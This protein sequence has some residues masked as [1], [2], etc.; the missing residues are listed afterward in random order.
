MTTRHLVM[1][2]HSLGSRL[3]L[4]LEL[5]DVLLLLASRNPLHEFSCL[6]WL[7]MDLM[8]LFFFCG[9]FWCF[10]ETSEKRQSWMGLF[11]LVQFQ[12][13]AAYCSFRDLKVQI[14]RDSI[15]YYQQSFDWRFQWTIRYQF[16]CSVILWI[17]CW[18]CCWGWWKFCSSM[19]FRDTLMGTV[20]LAGTDM[21]V[22]FF[23]C[24][25]FWGLNMLK[26]T[27][28][29]V[30]WRLWS[31]APAWEALTHPV[32][33]KGATMARPPSSIPAYIEESMKLLVCLIDPHR[34][35]CDNRTH[36]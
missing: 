36:Q 10:V 5:M 30:L 18:G 35:P 11:D 2:N 29:I 32:G 8:V 20:G 16:I 31:F 21:M 27:E 19:T 15:H 24:D 26:R 4:M 28:T 17:H 1:F 6:I 34:A 23:F 33:V 3:R 12:H 14:R 13:Q 25:F 7:V 22:L 9:C